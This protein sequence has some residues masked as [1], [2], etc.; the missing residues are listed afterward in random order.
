MSQTAGTSSIIISSDSEQETDAA[1][2]AESS[3]ISSNDSDHSPVSKKKRVVVRKRTSTRIKNMAASNPGNKN[4]QNSDKS[5]IRQ[6]AS[7]SAVT[8]DDEAAE[9][10]AA[11]LTKSGSI[12]SGDDTTDSGRT[13]DECSVCLDPPVHPVQLACQHT[14][15][16]LC[17]KGL[18][19]SDN[20]LCSLC[21]QPIAPGYLEKREIL[22]RVS[23][24]LND[25]PPMEAPQDEWQWFYEGR[26]GW[27]R[28]EARTNE[29][30]EETF[31][32]GQMSME[33]MIVGT[34]YILD[35]TRMEQYQK[36]RPNKK[37]KIKRDLK[38]S[39]C[40]GVAGVAKSTWKSGTG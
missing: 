35:F 37:R 39:D 32:S 2:S 10:V 33:L 15:C 19:M 30:L 4:S 6:S 20:A 22:A 24:D 12:K 5:E 27:W 14:F 18:V 9:T 21:R 17:A 7:H 25:T 13:G 40:K 31:L 34:I 16:Y 1:V 3:V 38:T 28:F 29:E 23:E 26:N 8:S 11:D 36:E